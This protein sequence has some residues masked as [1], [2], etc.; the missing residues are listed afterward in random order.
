[1]SAEAKLEEI[2]KRLGA[3]EVAK[4]TQGG[5]ADKEILVAF[6]KKLLVRLKEI[7]GA[8]GDG[9]AADMKKERDAA[10]AEVAVLK[11]ELERAEYRINH[12][13]KELNKAEGA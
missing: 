3:L 10:Q 13:V 6:Q 8:L 2:E 12:L 4:K 7:R 1:M 9:D 11:K 5:G